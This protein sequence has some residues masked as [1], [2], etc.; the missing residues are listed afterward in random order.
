[1]TQRYSKAEANT[2]LR[3]FGVAQE[4]IDAMLAELADP[5]DLERDNLVLERHGVTVSDLMEMM[6]SSP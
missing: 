4:R 3:R 5:I 6:G 1:M 2:F